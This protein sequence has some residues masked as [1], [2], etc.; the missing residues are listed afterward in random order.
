MTNGAF[1]LRTISRTVSVIHSKILRESS[2]CY[3]HVVGKRTD[4]L[5]FMYIIFFDRHSLCTTEFIQSRVSY[6]WLCDALEIYKPRQ[7][8]YGRLKLQGTFLSKRKIMK[9]VDLGIVKGWDDPRLYTL[10]ALRRRG[11]PPGAILSFVNG[12]GV[13]TATTTISIH[14]FEQAVRSYLEL[15]TPRL[16]F[17]LKP[18]KVT[19]EN[20]PEDYVEWIE[21]PLHTKNASMGSN[22]IPLTRNIYIDASD[23]RTVDSKDFFR[24]A[25]GKT[26]GL[27]YAGCPITCTSYKTDEKTGEVKEVL[28]RYEGFSVNKDEGRH[29]RC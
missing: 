3:A 20:V 6:E 16:M 2:P 24:L 10:I 15:N 12:L 13:T 1:T 11:I 26:V 8:E 18:L 4:I 22:K 28:A 7:S 29:G 9:L 5:N 21:K 19:L 27:L 17:V 25:P 14:R 23:F